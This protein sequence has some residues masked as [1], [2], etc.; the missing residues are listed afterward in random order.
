MKLHY[1]VS[2]SHM[3]RSNSSKCLTGI[4]TF[5]DLVLSKLSFNAA[6]W[7]FFVNSPPW[8]RAFEELRFFLKYLPFLII[9]TVCTDSWG[10][11][12]KPAKRDLVRLRWRINICVIHECLS[13]IWVSLCMFLECVW[14]PC[15]KREFFF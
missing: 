7:S 4:V 14:I 3:F 2:H 1:L 13:C 11:H 5:T 6:C 10:H 9:C 15:L 12:V 8:P